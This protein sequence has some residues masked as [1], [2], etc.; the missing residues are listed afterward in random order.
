MA[1]GSSKNDVFILRKESYET[2]AYINAGCLQVR[3]FEFNVRQGSAR[4][5]RPIEADTDSRSLHSAN[6]A[7]MQTTA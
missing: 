3:V 7:H 2:K 5:C 6:Q 4:L 1:I